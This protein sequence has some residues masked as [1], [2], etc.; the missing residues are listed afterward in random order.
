MFIHNIQCQHIIYGCRLEHDSLRVLEPYRA[1]VVDASRI[2][3]LG[4]S[5]AGLQ[6]PF[7]SVDLIA[8]MASGFPSNSFSSASD[9]AFFGH[10]STSPSTERQSPLTEGSSVT[11]LD[12]ISAPPIYRF[13]GRQT[14]CK[15]HTDVDGSG[16]EPSH[17][18]SLPPSSNAMPIDHDP[19]LAT[20]TWGPKKKAVLLN[21]NNERVDADLGPVDPE[22]ERNLY[23]LMSRQKLCNNYLLFGQC[24]QATLCPY[25]HTA[26]LNE[27]EM[28]ALVYHARTLPCERGS[29]CRSHRCWYGHTC[30]PDCTGGPKCFKKLHDVDRIAVKV[31]RPRV[32]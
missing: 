26:G 9:E 13:P 2:S 25:A 8:A 6:S 28:I 5:Q 27:N 23:R 32:L 16:L 21:V 15:D 17:F 12:D 10:F 11:T 1:N 19:A 24:A 20:K 22:A 14:R 7:A 4:A 18:S 29:E 31:W 30:V 3:L